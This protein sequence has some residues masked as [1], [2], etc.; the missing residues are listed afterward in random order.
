ME[1]NVKANQADPLKRRNVARFPFWDELFTLPIAVTN[2][3]S[4]HSNAICHKLFNTAHPNACRK[5]D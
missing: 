5:L 2:W 1:K 3:Y 4:T